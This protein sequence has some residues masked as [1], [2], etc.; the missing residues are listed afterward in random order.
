MRF[1]K[2]WHEAPK[3]VVQVQ[4]RHIYLAGGV[5][6]VMIGIAVIL[7]ALAIGATFREAQKRDSGDRITRTQVQHIAERVV[8][9][10]QPNNSQISERFRRC[11]FYQPCR[12]VIRK[13][14]F[15]T[16]GPRGRRGH[17]GSRGPAG[18]QGPRG[19]PGVGTPGRTGSAGRNGA[20]GS[21]GQQGQAGSQGEPG[22]TVTVPSPP[23]PQPPC[24]TIPHVRICP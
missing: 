17:T 12:D 22:V 4:R 3:E 18:P 16:R 23:S 11:F 5:I 1:K 19:L 8:H 9:L 7:A 15:F 2:I 6:G 10:E 13:Y 20:S 14:G 21:R 24:L